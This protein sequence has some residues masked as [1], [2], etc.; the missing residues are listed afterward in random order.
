M[1][2]HNKGLQFEVKVDRPDPIYARRLQE[3]LGGQWGEMTVAMQ[4]LLQGWNVRM[5]GKYKDLLL[6]VG[7]EELAHIEMLCIMIGRLLEGAPIEAQQAAVNGDPGIAAVMGGSNPQHAIVAGLGAVLKDSNGVPWS[8][9]YVTASGNLMADLHYNVTA[10]MQGRL[11]VARLYEM[12]DDKGVHDTL[13]FL[14]A[15]DTM[16][17]NMWLAAIEQVKEDGLEELP[18][19]GGKPTAEEN[20]AVAYQFWNMSSGTESMEGRW[21]KGPTPDGKGEFT[22]L[23]NPGPTTTEP[24]PPAPHPKLYVTGD[25]KGVVAGAVDKV[26]DA[27]R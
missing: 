12:T 27:L 17:Q 4:Y 19:P 25:A 22:Y 15:R 13:S 8:G 5:P 1:F 20:R 7:T 3:V 18:V 24:R 11:Q 9:G 16:H 23:E 2:F 26:K 14:L 21:A 10:E 6:D